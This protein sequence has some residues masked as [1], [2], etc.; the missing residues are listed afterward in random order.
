MLFV[1]QARYRPRIAR[2]AL[3]AVELIFMWCCIWLVRGVSALKLLGARN[4]YLSSD[5]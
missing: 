2:Q 1:D 4:E 3:R 5:I